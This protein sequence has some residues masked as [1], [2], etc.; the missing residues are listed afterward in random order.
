MRSEMTNTISFELWMILSRD[1]EH[2]HI[3]SWNYYKLLSVLGSV[4]KSETVKRVHQYKL[5]HLSSFRVDC[6]LMCFLWPPLPW[7]S[8]HCCLFTC[9]TSKDPPQLVKCVVWEGTSRMGLELWANGII[10]SF[11]VLGNHL[12]GNYRRKVRLMSGQIRDKWRAHM[13]SWGK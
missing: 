8:S 10:V 13:V 11:R 6:R 3:V 9:I 2:L 7:K 5:E 1:Y 4:I 12:G